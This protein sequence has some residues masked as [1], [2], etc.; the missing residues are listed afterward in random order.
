MRSPSVPTVSPQAHPFHPTFR[1]ILAPKCGICGS[2]PLR[3]PSW[4]P[5]RDVSEGAAEE[6][7]EL[8]RSVWRNAV[9]PAGALAGPAWKRPKMARGSP[10]LR[11]KKW[12]YGSKACGLLGS[13]AKTSAAHE[14]TKHKCATMTVYRRGPGDLCTRTPT[15]TPNNDPNRWWI[16]RV[17]AAD[18]EKK[19]K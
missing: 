1:V 5:A 6:N 18:L 11:S 9:I 13:R 17:L 16:R 2:A 14:H 19:T 15:M 10:Y 8:R 12:T 4:R 3:A 7:R